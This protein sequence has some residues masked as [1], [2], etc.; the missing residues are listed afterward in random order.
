MTSF[1]YLNQV[2]PLL[3]TVTTYRSVNG[4]ADVIDVRMNW[5]VVQKHAVDHES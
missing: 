5:N 4:T 1:P 3:N 2:L